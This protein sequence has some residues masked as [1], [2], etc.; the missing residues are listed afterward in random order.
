METK[1]GFKILQAWNEGGVTLAIVPSL[2]PASP[3]HQL[4]WIQL[5]ASEARE[6]GEYF[7]TLADICESNGVKPA[8]VEDTR[9]R[10]LLFLQ[11][12]IRLRELDARII[13]VAIGYGYHTVQKTITGARNHP[14]CQNAI[15]NYL[16]LD[17]EKVHG[18]ESIQY[19]KQTILIEVSKIASVKAETV[20]LE[21]LATYTAQ[22]EEI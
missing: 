20:R 4:P 21:F 2:A 16:G 18:N 15:A 3:P 7:C 9:R 22:L 1:S 8:R 19:L 5:T 13:A 6:I 12:L 17:P 14:A 11:Q 10:T